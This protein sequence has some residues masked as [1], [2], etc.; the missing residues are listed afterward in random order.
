[1]VIHAVRSHY[2][3]GADRRPSGR[4]IIV[5]WP[6]VVIHPKVS[7]VIGLGEV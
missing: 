2:I 3:G 4:A 7:L 1:M 5:R 6:Y